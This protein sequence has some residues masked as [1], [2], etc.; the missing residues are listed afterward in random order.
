MEDKDIRFIILTKD[1]VRKVDFS[2]VNQSPEDLRYTNNGQATFVSYYGDQPSFVFA[3]TNNLIGKQEYSHKE[4]KSFLTD[5]D[6]A[7]LPKS[8]R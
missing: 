7:W 5:K 2:K 3:I 6:G 4:M 8:S 1:Q